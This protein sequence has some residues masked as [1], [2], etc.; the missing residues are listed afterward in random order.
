MIVRQLLP[1]LNLTSMLP[2]IDEVVMTK[3]AQ[4]P[5]QFTSIYRMNKST[6]S[7]E[8]TTEVTGFGTIPV[9][10]DGA[11]LRYDT[12]LPAFK[13]TYLHLQYGMGF[14]VTKVTFD[15]D[16]FGV[17]K[18]LAVELGRS[19]HET[20]EITA[21]QNFNTG[22]NS[23]YPGPD[24]VALFSAS[25]PL[26]GGG[27]QSNVLSMAADP[28][29]DSMRLILTLMRRTV[30]HRGLLQR[31]V[32]KMAIFPPE[33]EFVGAELL[34]GD[35][36]PDTANRAINA[37][38]RRSGMP[39]FESWCVWD[40]LKDPGAWFVMADPEDTELRWYDREAFNTVHGIDFESRSLKTAGW[41]Q[42]SCGWNG[43]FGVAGAPSS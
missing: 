41:M 3:Y 35:Q 22:F 29:V 28:D 23:A 18:K 24:G 16:Q 14:K 30:N 42:F 33:L 40:Y 11:G 1:D 38:K 39:S 32:P 26:A 9:V 21:A 19:A 10:G 20:R 36:R 4:Y 31:I 2:A 25:H 7:I 17:M 8:Q 37:F 15:N 43:F 27:V 12:P 13:K 5:P 6:R 34:G